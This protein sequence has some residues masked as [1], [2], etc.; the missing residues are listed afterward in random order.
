MTIGQKIKKIRELRNYTQEYVAEKLQISQPGYAKIERDESE[1]NFSRL[2]KIAG[3]L[4]VRVE[5]IIGFDEKAMLNFMYNKHGHNNGLVVNQHVS[6]LEKKL[7]EEKAK[8]QDEYIHQLKEEIVYLRKL[9][10]RLQT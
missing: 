5:D 7:Y 2:E 3:V 9:L 10:D 6:E 4:G 8:S 1:V